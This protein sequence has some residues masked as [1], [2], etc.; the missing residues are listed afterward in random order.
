V[1]DA[2]QASFPVLSHSGNESILSSRSQRGLSLVCV[3]DREI[4]SVMGQFGSNIKS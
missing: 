3:K 1:T 2:L 4:A